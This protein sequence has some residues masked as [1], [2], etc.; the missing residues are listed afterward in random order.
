MSKK[1]RIVVSHKADGSAFAVDVSEVAMAR[2]RQA[3]AKFRDSSK[4]FSRE[5]VHAAKLID[6]KSGVLIGSRLKLLKS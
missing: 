1:Y 2:A 5:T 3:S 4:V 6:V